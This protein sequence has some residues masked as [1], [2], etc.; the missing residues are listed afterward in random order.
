ML[1]E[2]CRGPD[3]FRSTPTQNKAQGSEASRRQS[4]S[5][6]QCRMGALRPCLR[7]P[8]SNCWTR[9]ILFRYA[10]SFVL[11]LYWRRTG[12]IENV[13]S[14]QISLGGRA[15]LSPLQLNSRSDTSLESYRAHY[16]ELWPLVVLVAASLRRAERQH[17]VVLGRVAVPSALLVPEVLR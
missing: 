3:I 7:R 16:C 13:F 5:H 14:C 10:S 17:L 4:S 8:A 1:S 2:P 15:V 12:T 6:L 11:L 9:H